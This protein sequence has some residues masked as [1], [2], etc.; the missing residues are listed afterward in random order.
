MPHAEKM[1]A[2][3]AFNESNVRSQTNRAMA[4]IMARAD[5]NSLPNDVIRSVRDNVV[6]SKPRTPDEVRQKTGQEL[7]SQLRSSGN[8]ELAD[9]VAE[10]MKH[11]SGASE[12]EKVKPR[13]GHGDSGSHVK[14]PSSGEKVEPSQGHKKSPFSGKDPM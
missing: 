14:A 5:I 13:A 9:K 1:Q 8:T 3:Q 4:T 11:K 6:R 10:A 2:P 12:G 7:V